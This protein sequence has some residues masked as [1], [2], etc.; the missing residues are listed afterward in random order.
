M[1]TRSCWVLMGLISVAV[2]SG[3]AQA[4]I[5]W[6]GAGWYVEATEM[7]FDAA[8]VSGPYTDEGACNAAR[9]ADNDD[10]SYYCQYE[11]TDPN[12]EQPPRDERH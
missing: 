12:S 4:D 10:E 7:G 3:S 8:L 6:S 5:S 11:G 1:R 2:A 9:P